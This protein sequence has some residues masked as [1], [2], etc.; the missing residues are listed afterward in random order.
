M[1][2]FWAPVPVRSCK[3][4]GDLPKSKLPIVLNSADTRCVIT[5]KTWPL[6]VAKTPKDVQIKCKHSHLVYT[7]SSQKPAFI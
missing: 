3:Q 6:L 2:S 1:G 7:Q 5:A 4:L